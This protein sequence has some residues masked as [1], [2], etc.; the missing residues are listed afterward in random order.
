MIQV[1]RVAQTLFEA[2]MLNPD[3]CTK[4]KIISALDFL[5]YGEIAET[6]CKNGDKNDKT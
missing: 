3:S 2:L 5:G 1:D 6:W 4:F